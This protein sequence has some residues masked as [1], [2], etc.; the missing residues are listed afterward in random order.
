MATGRARKASPVSCARAATCCRAT[1][2]S[3]RCTASGSAASRRSATGATGRRRSGRACTARRSGDGRLPGGRGSTVRFHQF[4]QWLAVALVR[5]GAGGRA[6][7]RHAD[8]PDQR[9]RHRHGPRRQPCLVAPE[10][11]AARARAS[12]RRPTSSIAQGQDWGLTAFS[13]R[14]LVG[15]GFAPFLATLRAAL[16]HA[17]G[18]RIDHVMGLQRLWLV[19][20]R[21]ARRRTAPISPI[22]STICCACWRSNRIA[23]APS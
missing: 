21:R 10:R 11:P 6:R 23:T 16:R 4:L 15:D 9:S 8:R 17:G 3:R 19:P 7:R 13:P 5:G 22:R 14:A 20:R 2:C 12:A 1:P 18:V